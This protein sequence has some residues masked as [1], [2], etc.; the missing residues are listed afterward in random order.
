MSIYVY[1]LV[2]FF[3]PNKFLSIFKLIPFYFTVNVYL[4]KLAFVHSHNFVR[5]PYQSLAPFP[6]PIVKWLTFRDKTRNL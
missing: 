2:I 4:V 1:I 5:F 3:L 6:R